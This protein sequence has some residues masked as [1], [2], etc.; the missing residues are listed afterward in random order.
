MINAIVTKL[1]SQL[2]DAVI[3]VNR[4]TTECNSKA[5]TV[6][7]TVTNFEATAVLPAHV[8]IAIYVNG[9]YIQSTQTQNQIEVDGSESGSVFLN[10][11]ADT[12]SPFEVQ[13]VVDDDGNH[14]GTVAELRENNNTFT[15]N[16]SLYIS[17]ALAILDELVSCNEGYSVGTFDFS[18]YENQIKQSPTDVVTF[19]PTALDLENGTNEITDLSNYVAPST[20]MSIYVKVDNGNCFNTTSFLLKTKKCKPVVYNF[21][22][23]NDDGINDTF[24]I[25]GLRDVFLNYRLHVYNRWGRLVWTGNNNTPEWN[26]VADQGIILNDK[27]TTNGTYF[28]SLELHD[29]DYP[30]PLYGYLF[31]SE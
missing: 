28:Y 29:D 23:R 4:V 16:T 7:Y 17:D 18:A 13:L 1:N 5:I 19:Y 2:P 9:T 15:Q 30:T 24:R 22:S 31:L 10:L 12:I 25:K 21:I 27:Q 3:A 20:P 26:G 6:H 11:P 8:P 14:Q